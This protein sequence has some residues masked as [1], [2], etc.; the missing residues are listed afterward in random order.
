MK[1][2]PVKKEAFPEEIAG[3]IARECGIE[4]TEAASLLVTPPRPELGDF[5][6]PCFQLAKRLRKAPPAIA[7]EL[8]AKLPPGLGLFERV[9]AAGPYVN[10]AVKRPIFAEAVLR[11]AIA[12]GAAYG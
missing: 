7:Q 10:F 11:E 1:E 3:A 4:A 6:F 9:A 2:A 5:A 12:D 8:A